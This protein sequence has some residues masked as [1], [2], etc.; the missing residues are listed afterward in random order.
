MSSDKLIILCDQK[1][2][3]SPLLRAFEALGKSPEVVNIRDWVW[4]PS[5][6][7]DGWGRVVNRVSA[8]PEVAGGHPTSMLR[9][10][11]DVL[12]A[13][14]LSGI[15]CINGSRAYAVGSSKA[16]QAVCFHQAKVKTPLTVFTTGAEEK[17]TDGVEWLVKPNPGGFGKA[18]GQLS[19][20]GLAA[21]LAM[22]GTAVMQKQIQVGEPFVYRAEF[23]GG[24]L[25][26]LAASPLEAGETNYC[27]AGAGDE[28]KLSRHLPRVIEEACQKI[29]KLSQMDL[30]SIEYLID[31]T[32]DPV[33]IDI[34][35]VSSP[36]PGVFTSLGVDIWQL[37]A[38]YFFS[39]W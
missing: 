24:E 5:E 26:Y 39:S 28:V 17:L 15:G 21:A 35:P 10:T 6:G 23:I 14:E 4:S 27:L 12:A 8:R 9:K 19:S 30:G 7:F 32:G 31:S 2:W 36:H 16:L 38:E 34:N 22:D 18:V 13:L 3:L 1:A 25:A 33:F 11:Q 29:L 37:Q 20:A